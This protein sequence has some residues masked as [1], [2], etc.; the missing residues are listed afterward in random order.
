M[1]RLL[2]I[3]LVTIRVTICPALCASSAKLCGSCC[4]SRTTL[5]APSTAPKT[6]CDCCSKSD[7]HHDWG[8]PR[9]SVTPDDEGCPCEPLTP[10]GGDCSCKTVPFKTDKPVEF[11]VVSSPIELPQFVP[12][13]DLNGSVSSVRGAP[14]HI[15]DD[16]R[17][18]R[19]SYCSLVV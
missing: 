17:H 15:T 18:L 12:S 5:Q 3:L 16:G 6:H 4:A 13:S 11:E 1:A 10:C 8:L 9:G 19:I 7:G 2:I 14:A